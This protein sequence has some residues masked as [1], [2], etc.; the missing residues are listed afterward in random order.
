MH[1][2]NIYAAF[3]KWIEVELMDGEN[4]Y[5]AEGHGKQVSSLPAR[6]CILGFHLA[7]ICP[8]SCVLSC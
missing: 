2:Q 8:V 4:M 3:E 5:E 6:M 7:A 1:F